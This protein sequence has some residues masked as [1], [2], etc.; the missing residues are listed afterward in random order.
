MEQKTCDSVEHIVGQ[1]SFGVAV[2]VP[3]IDKRSERGTTCER[4]HSTA[5][6][7]SLEVNTSRLTRNLVYCYEPVPAH[8]HTHTQTLA[9]SPADHR[10]KKSFFS[11]F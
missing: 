6:W 3:K 5:E 2:C 7:N 4:P 8:T 11:S 1:A 10:E 9:I